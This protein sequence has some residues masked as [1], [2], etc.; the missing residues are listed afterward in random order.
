MNYIIRIT[1][2]EGQ[3]KYIQRMNGK[4]GKP[5]LTDSIKNA[6]EYTETEAAEHL[7]TVK[8][9][10]RKETNG[11]TVTA[12][13]VP[14][15]NDKPGADISVSPEPP[16]PPEPPKTPPERSKYYIEGWGNPCKEISESPRMRH[17]CMYQRKKPDGSFEF[18]YANEKGEIVVVGD[19]PHEI[20][21]AFH[22]YA[23]HVSF[24]MINKWEDKRNG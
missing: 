12:E 8:G 6:R 7:E 19:N 18:A 17:I 14:V 9:F 3:P 10:I 20:S 13:L 5:T 23:D 15:E 4:P 21:R 11:E 2:D 22:V 16:P 1:T 24:L